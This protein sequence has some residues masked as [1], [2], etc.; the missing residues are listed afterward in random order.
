[1]KHPSLTELAM[2]RLSYPCYITEH[3]PKKSFSIPNT[4]DF[5]CYIDHECISDN[6]IAPWIAV[7]RF[8]IVTDVSD[9]QVFISKSSNGSMVIFYQVNRNP[10]VVDRFIFKFE[11]LEDVL[12]E[13]GFGDAR[14][15]EPFKFIVEKV[16]QSNP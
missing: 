14:Y 5:P 15:A 9:E 16:K 3:K 11:R 8:D 7:H 12:K 10:K 6:L 4:N 13:V 1:M 2:S